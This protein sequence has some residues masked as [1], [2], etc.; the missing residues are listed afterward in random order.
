MAVGP[1]GDWPGDGW[2]WRGGIE[3]WSDGGLFSWGAAA[4]GRPGR[5][6]MIR[7]RSGRAQLERMGERV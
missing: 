5:P 6:S 1:R 2:F 7:W 4:P 3:P